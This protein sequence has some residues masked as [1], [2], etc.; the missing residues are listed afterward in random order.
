[1]ARFPLF[2]KLQAPP[3]YL[4]LTNEQLSDPVLLIVRQSKHGPLVK[5]K[6]NSTSSEGEPAPKKTAEER[7]NAWG[8]AAA[9]DLYNDTNHPDPQ[10]GSVSGGNIAKQPKDRFQANWLRLYPWLEHNNGEMN[11]PICKLYGAVPFT[12]RCYKT[13]TLRCHSHAVSH[14]FLAFVK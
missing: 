9:S 13:S 8:G 10:T 6:S 11:C 14:M 7:T 4:S 3:H 5:R 1:M 12:S 2:F